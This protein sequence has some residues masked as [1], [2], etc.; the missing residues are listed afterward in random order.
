MFTRLNSG[1]RV[2]SRNFL[3]RKFSMIFVPRTRQFSTASK[4]YNQQLCYNKIFFGC[5]LAV[6][7]EMTCLFVYDTQ[8]RKEVI[9]SIC[10]DCKECILQREKAQDA[11]NDLIH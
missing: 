10:K 11:L 8:K 2:F 3:T 7:L 6:L 4:T 9:C 5:T 1:M